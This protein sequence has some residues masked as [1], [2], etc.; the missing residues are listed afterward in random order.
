MAS[1]L[2]TALALFAAFLVWRHFR[3]RPDAADPAANLF[4]L[5]CAISTTPYMLSYD[6]LSFAAMAIFFWA[7][8]RAACSASS[9][10]FLPLIQIVAGMI[11]VPGPGVVPIL[12]AALLSKAKKTSIRY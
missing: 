12:T 7:W 8:G 11:G 1:A 5:A 9:P 4:F 2:Q 6:T 3:R 10:F